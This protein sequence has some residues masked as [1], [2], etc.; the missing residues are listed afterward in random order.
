MSFQNARRF[1]L[2]RGPGNL[3]DRCKCSEQQHTGPPPHA[4]LAAT[5]RNTRAAI[6]QT[7]QAAVSD[8]IL[9]LSKGLP[10]PKADPQG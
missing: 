4:A 3:G 9:S 1:P 2:L 6:C 7:R 5:L 10:G 8:S